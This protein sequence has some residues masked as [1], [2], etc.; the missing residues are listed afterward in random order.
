MTAPLAVLT[1][2]VV[3]GRIMP[4]VGALAGAS[5]L[6][7]LVVVG[8]VR[9]DHDRAIDDVA[10]H[11]RPAIVTTQSAL[12][13]LAWRLDGRFGW[14]LVPVDDVPSAASAAADRPGGA[15]V[16]TGRRERPVLPGFRPVPARE[17]ESDLLRLWESR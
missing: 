9:R 13:R 11:A 10:A 4:A 7:A 15:L 16:A 6:A 8:T 5:A 14:L 3:R 17:L 2:L 1:A 12:P